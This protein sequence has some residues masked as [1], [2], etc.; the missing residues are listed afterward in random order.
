MIQAS[1]DHQGSPWDRERLP[2]HRY[3]AVAGGTAKCANGAFEPSTNF[4]L[5]SM[6]ILYGRRRHRSLIQEDCQIWSMESCW[7][8]LSTC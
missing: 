8:S 5:V 1:R 7:V 2:G 3:G 6:T 4:S